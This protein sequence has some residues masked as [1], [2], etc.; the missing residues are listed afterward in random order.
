MIRPIGSAMILHWL[1]WFGLY[2]AAGCGGIAA[3]RLWRGEP[4]TASVF[5]SRAPV[6]VIIAGAL[7]ALQV[8]RDLRKTRK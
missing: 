7:V 3:I 6:L 5:V 2:L 4:I 1:G 8:A